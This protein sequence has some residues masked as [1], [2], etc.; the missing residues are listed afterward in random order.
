MVVNGGK[1]ANERGITKHRF[2]HI[3][4][5]TI[6]PTTSLEVVDVCG[7]GDA[8]ISVLTL[9]YLSGLSPEHLA[10]AA[11]LAGGAVCEHVGVAPITI[12]VLKK[13]LDVERFL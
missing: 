3:G 10:Y 6:H 5:L 12:E 8:V 7:A 1:P 4:R 9:G 2:Y 13:A 11:N